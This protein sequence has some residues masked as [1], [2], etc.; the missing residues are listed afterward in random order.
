MLRIEDRVEGRFDSA[1]ARFHFHPDVKCMA[2]GAG[3]SGHIRLINGH[4]VRWN[5]SGGPAR[6]E[7]SQYCPEFGLRNPTQC[8]A[9]EIGQAAH[10]SLELTW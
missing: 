1:V 3:S 2:D 5:A 10:V 7:P 9:V 6:I 4:E 8:L